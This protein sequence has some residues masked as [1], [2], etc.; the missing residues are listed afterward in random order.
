MEQRENEPVD[1]PER[2]P[3]RVLPLQHSELVAQRQISTSSDA[4]DR[5]NPVRPNQSN[6]Q[7]D[8]QREISPDSRLRVS[9]LEF[10]IGTRCREWPPRA[11]HV[12]A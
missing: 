10:P 5:N 12:L 3:R 1:I 9:H 8:H 2:R 6:L 11:L 7:I 4:R